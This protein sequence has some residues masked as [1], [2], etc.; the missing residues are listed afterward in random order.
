MNMF[1]ARLILMTNCNLI[2]LSRFLF[3]S[4]TFKVHNSF[5]R[6]LQNEKNYFPTFIRLKFYHDTKFHT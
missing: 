5:S 4:C 2:P 6:Q 1:T 3:M